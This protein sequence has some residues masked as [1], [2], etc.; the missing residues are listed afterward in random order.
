MAAK[1]TPIVLALIVLDFSLAPVMAASPA[2]KSEKPDVLVNSPMPASWQKLTPE[3]RAELLKSY[4]ALRQLDD[5]DRQDLQ[6]RMEW[7][8][9]LPKDQQQRMREV[10]QNMSDSERE[11][12]KAQ[13]KTASSPEQREE[14]REKIMQKYD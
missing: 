2:K 6:Q 13:L 1:F 5:K 9:Q 4:Q 12:W 8:S 11:H 7:F 3:E 14:L 10:W